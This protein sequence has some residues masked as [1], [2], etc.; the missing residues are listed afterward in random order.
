[1]DKETRPQGRQEHVTGGNGEIRKHGDG[2]GLGG[3]QGNKE[4]FGGRPDLK[5]ERNY[6]GGS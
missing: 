6:S 5:N 3:P 4:G 1:M 2:L